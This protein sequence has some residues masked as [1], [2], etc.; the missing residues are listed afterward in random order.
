MIKVAKF[1]RKQA[2]KAERMAR[3]TADEETAKGLSDLAMA[4]RTQADA[5]K[6]S[7]KLKK[8]PAKKRRESK[9]E[10]KGWNGREI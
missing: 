7:K 4:Y 5:L 6:K 3:A 1:F 9:D 8:Q 10:V 2:D